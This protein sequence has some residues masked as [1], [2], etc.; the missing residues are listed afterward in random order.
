MTGTV[1]AQTSESGVCACGWRSAASSAARADAGLQRHIDAATRGDVVA[2]LPRSGSLLERL[3]NAL[4][5]M[6]S[7]GWLLLRSLG[8]SID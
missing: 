5:R 7:F 3:V 6:Q 2:A 4:F 8:T 1:H